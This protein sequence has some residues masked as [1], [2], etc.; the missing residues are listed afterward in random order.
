MDVEAA[1]LQAIADDDLVTAACCFAAAEDPSVT[2]AQ[3]RAQLDALSVGLRLSPSEPVVGRVA[4]VIRHLFADLGFVGDQQTYD[5][6]DNSLL[7][8]VISR[9]RGL[10]ILLSVV[11]IGVGENVG[12]PLVG[13]GFPGHFLVMPVEADPPFLLD[14][15][16]GGEVRRITDLR[17][18]LSS[19]GVSARDQAQMLAPTDVKAILL[20]MSHNLRGSYAARGLP[21]ARVEARIAAIL[22]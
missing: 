15:F 12:L 3:V 9:R 17:G 20:R 4:R 22:G 1:L 10:P 21:T 6:P 14:P 11:L 2:P 19:R 7:H 18:L 5:H 16:H 8:R 13:I